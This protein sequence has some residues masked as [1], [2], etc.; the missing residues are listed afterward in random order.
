MVPLLAH[1]TASRTKEHIPSSKSEVLNHT[2][3]WQS[4]DNRQHLKG[5]SQKC[6]PLH[7][8]YKT[9][10]L[11]THQEPAENLETASKI[12]RRTKLE[13]YWQGTACP[14]Q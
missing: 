13:N 2:A 12:Q 1:N 4:L 9:L 11:I 5:V 7:V 3:A 8:G 6:V 10:R 14:F